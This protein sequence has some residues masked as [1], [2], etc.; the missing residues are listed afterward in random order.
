MQSC[1]APCAE[2]KGIEG[3][4]ST[5]GQP[6][7]RA[8]SMHLLHPTAGE[9]NSSCRWDNDLTRTGPVTLLLKGTS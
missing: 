7:G 3:E 9:M 5:G 1:G 4:R 8:G 6:E 2:L